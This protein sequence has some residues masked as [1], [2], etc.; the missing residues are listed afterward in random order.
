MSVFAERKIDCHNHIFDPAKF[1]YQPDSPY[2]PEGHE[3]T[4]AEYFHHVLDT[5]GV[6]H[7]VLVGP[8]SGYGENDNRALLDAIKNSHGRF[9]G[10][11]VVDSQCSLQTLQAL[12]AQG[13]VG[14]TFNVALYGVEHFRHAH[15]L[16]EKLKELDLISQIQVT[17]EQLLPLQAM[18]RDAGTKIVID[19]CGRPDL[20][21]GIKRDGFRAVLDLADTG[22]AWIKVSGFDKFS[23]ESYPY[24]DCLPTVASIQSAYGEDRVLWGSDWPFLKPRQHMDYGTVLSLAVQHFPNSSAREKYFWRNAATLYGFDSAG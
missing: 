21:A 10:M 5:Y 22:R 17:G 3:I 7:A 20:Q 11:A 14:V 19:H 1:P 8:N 16:L 12:K 2:H 23:E 9:K 4:S 6:S 15:A 18:F 13:V 24:R